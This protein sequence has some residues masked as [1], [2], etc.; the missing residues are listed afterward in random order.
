M[1]R[2]LRPV[3]R[4]IAMTSQVLKS[5]AL[6]QEQTRHM[7]FLDEDSCRIG[8][9][10]STS[11]AHFWR[12]VIQSD[13]IHPDEIKK[14]LNERG[15]QAGIRQSWFVF[16]PITLLDSFEATPTA[17]QLLRVLQSLSSTWTVEDK[18]EESERRATRTQTTW[19][20]F[21]YGFAYEQSVLVHLAVKHSVTQC[22][23]LLRNFAWFVIFIFFMATDE[24]C[25][26]TTQKR[27]TLKKLNAWRI[28]RR[29]RF[30]CWKRNPAMVARWLHNGTTN[31]SVKLRWPE[32][33]PWQPW[34]TA[35]RGHWSGFKLFQVAS[36][37]YS[38]IP[39]CASCV[40]VKPWK[41]FSLVK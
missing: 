6:K 8:Q 4:M 19:R 7:F 23:Q 38:V 36:T 24:L 31:T 3:W 21:K 13:Q 15:L 30:A 9:S 18:V 12:E 41:P 14:A 17:K 27:M 16:V 20:Y 11:F 1:K 10:C 35:L 22:Q 29:L 26:G 39:S 33:S 32:A 25:A 5:Q 2:K 28:R 34:W 40:R 37:G